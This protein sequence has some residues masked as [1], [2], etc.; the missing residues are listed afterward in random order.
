MKKGDLVSIVIPVYNGER[1]IEQCV[2]SVLQQT[3]QD[4]ELILIDDG[5][6]DNTADIC[7]QLVRKCKKIRYFCQ[8]NAGP[9]AARNLGLKKVQGDYV[10]FIDADDFVHPRYIEELYQALKKNK[11]LIA[12]CACIKIKNREEACR[13]RMADEEVILSTEEALTSLFYGKEIKGYSS[14]K[15]IHISLLEDL[16]FPENLCVGED[17]VWV[18][19]LLMRCERIVYINKELYYYVQNENSI[20][21]TMKIEEMLLFWD[22]MQSEL[23]DKIVLRYPKIEKAIRVKKFMTAFK[24]I[25][26]MNQNDRDRT[27]SREL[28]LFLKQNCLAIV[29]DKKCKVSNRMVATLCCINVGLAI[30]FIKGV[31]Q[32]LSKIGLQ[33]KKAV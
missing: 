33:L 30:V 24:W 26:F 17:F 13:A 16:R 22:T 28:M 25:I 6:N 7:N 15:M 21:H 2:K 8:E 27:E 4:I 9:G 12:S 1:C 19:Q 18:Y 32:V 5:S 14:L 29:Q 11:I 31:L 10:T 20:V 3:Y 23:I